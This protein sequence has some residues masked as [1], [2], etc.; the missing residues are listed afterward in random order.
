M[1]SE[2]EKRA[3]AAANK[4][5]Y[6]L[7]KKQEAELSNN[8]PKQPI[9][10]STPNPEAD[11]RWRTVQTDGKPISAEDIVHY[12]DSR[13]KSEAILA[14]SVAREEMVALLFKPYA[15]STNLPELLQ[16]IIREIIT[17]RVNLTDLIGSLRK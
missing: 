1:T 6:R 8:L 12:V 13:E 3:R 4:R 16:G 14:E 17:L 5:A 9:F 7:R 10:K 15:K 11:E 2:E